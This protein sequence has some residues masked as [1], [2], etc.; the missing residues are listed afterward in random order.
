[1]KNKLHFHYDFEPR[2]ILQAP[3]AAQRIA[4][5]KQAGVETVWLDAYAY[6]THLATEQELMDAKK[7]LEQHGFRVQVLTVPVGHG[8]G[9]LLGD[10]G[11]PGIPPAWQSRINA[12][13]QPVAFASCMR[14]E[15]MLDDSRAVAQRYCELGFTEIFFDDDLR[16]GP[17]G[18]ALQGCCC[19]ACMRAFGQ[20]YPQYAH[21]SAPEIFAA[22]TE[23]DD[24][25]NAW[26]DV[27]CDAVLSFLEQTVPDG[28]TPGVMVMHNGDRRHGVDINRIKKRYPNALFRVGE[29]HF[30]D[31][32]FTHP[33]AGDAIAHSIR[34]HLCAIGS[35]ENA[36]SESTVYPENAL[37]P[38]HLVQKL[39]LEISLGL[40]NLFL[41]S[42][43]FFLDEP[44]WQAIAAARPE[45]DAL[46]E[47]TPIDIPSTSN[48]FIWQ[49]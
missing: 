47:R 18:P 7:L 32:S 40:R 48:D 6:G 20:K 24:L 26:S 29:G 34:A 39:R 5:M 36:F 37:S 19:P 41:M 16:A 8:G 21:L 10:G 17:W 30:E 38:E 12:S 43:L 15:R 33:L 9:A 22:A 13:G 1:M 14:G 31:A 23:G 45:L 27:Q 28:M 4:W 2:A 25:W 44:Y 35:S 49:L 11:D 3:N 46:A 42:G